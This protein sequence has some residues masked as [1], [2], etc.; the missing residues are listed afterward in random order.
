MSCVTG[1]YRNLLLALLF[2]ENFA[3]GLGHFHASHLIL[4]MTVLN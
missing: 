3:F 2:V 1:L 4:V